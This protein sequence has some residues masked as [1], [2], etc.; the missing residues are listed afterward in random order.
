MSNTELWVLDGLHQDRNRLG[1]GG[2]IPTCC[3]CHTSAF[4]STV[5]LRLDSHKFASGYP[6]GDPLI[7]GGFL[8]LAN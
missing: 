5:H 3:H 2:Q 8:L 4:L 1:V 7:P 6:L